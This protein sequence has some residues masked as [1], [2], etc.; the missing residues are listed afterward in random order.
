MTK[1]LFFLLWI[2]FLSVSGKTLLAQSYE[3][4]I[5]INGLKDEPL[6]MGHY[7]SKTT[8]VDDTA[9]TNNNGIAVFK[10]SK[11]LP[12][13]MYL[14][15][16]PNSAYF[17]MIVGDDQKF[18]LETDTTEFIKN[19]KIK[20]SEENTQFRN[21]QLF[22][23]DLRTSAQELQQNLQAA[24]T[25]EEKESISQ[26]LKTVNKERIRYIDSIASA[27][28]DIFVSKFLKATVDIQV[29]DPPK[30]QQ[31]NITDP[32]WQYRYY[33]KHYFDNFDFS[34]PRLLRTPLYEGKIMNYISKVIP[35]IP[36]SIIPETDMLIES[37]RHDSSLFRY[38]LITLF[39]HFGNSQI[40]GMD[41]VQ[42]HI[43][44]KFYITDSWWS[45]DKF[46]EDLK[47]RV[48]KLKPLLIGKKAPDIQLVWVP[49][50]HFTKAQNDTAL[51]RYPHAG[52]F[53]NL[54]DLETDFIILLFWE[55]DCGH[56][57][58]AVP[59]MNK[60]YTNELKDKSVEVISVSTLFGEEGKID[61]INF[62]NKH[63]LYGWINAWNPYDYQ[64]KLS[65][66]IQSTPTM[67]VLDKEKKIIAKKVSPEQARDIINML[68]DKNSL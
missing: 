32:A 55:A 42:V 20:G 18:S 19:M 15:V 60:I 56:C 10:G 1:K 68:R 38:M 6:I 21:F 66:D 27:Y 3:I 2:L 43:A 59:K 31:G 23:S 5:E 28:P 26:K 45:N 25:D 9:I 58:T 51:K 12:E 53:F 17:E 67:F 40:M 52:K 64:F 39:N 34:D 35:Q 33:K 46:I 50:E 61:W 14:I 11:K 57:K 30:D 47:E 13:G 54:Y 24:E 41:A 37:T 36:D 22:M 49:D 62:V 44:E 48:E 8:L 4:R 65:Y 16:L 29:P 7:L 63:K